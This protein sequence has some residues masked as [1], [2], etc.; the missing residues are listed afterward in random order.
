MTWQGTEQDF[1]PPPRTR[2]GARLR[3]AHDHVLREQDH[4][5]E[6]IEAMKG[7]GAANA[8]DKMGELGGLQ[9][10]DERLTAMGVS[11]PPSPRDWQRWAVP[12]EQT[13]PNRAAGRFRKSNAEAAS[14]AHFLTSVGEHRERTRAMALLAELLDASPDSPEFN[15]ALLMWVTYHHLHHYP[16]AKAAAEREYAG[17]PTSQKGVD[18]ALQDLM[19]AVAEKLT[20]G[21]RTPATAGQ[22]DS[23]AST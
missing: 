12:W 20:A 13:P 5:H 18:D 8:L 4:W 3:D 6:R 19:K 23:I 14:W 15:F 22:M 21:R 17:R 7:K 10:L 9:A 16:E 2:L 11:Y 1:R